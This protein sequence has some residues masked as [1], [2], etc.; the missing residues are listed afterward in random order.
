MTNSESMACYGNRH[1]AIMRPPS[2]QYWW[3]PV[4]HR[5]LK[6]A[7]VAHTTRLTARTGRIRETVA[8]I[9]PGGAQAPW[10]EHRMFPI[11]L[12][13]FK[14][15]RASCMCSTGLLLLIPL[16]HP[17][18]SGL[19]RHVSEQHPST[20]N[21]SE[22]RASCALATPGRHANGMR[23][24]REAAS[25][26]RPSGARATNERRWSGLRTARERHMSSAQAGSRSAGHKRS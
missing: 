16:L 18:R 4:D 8:A 19:F 1:R 5:E 26:R 2:R 20:S 14:L 22:L 15:R 25:E 10:L 11:S 24:T 23:A 13:P 12:D 3:K 9:Q 21:A 7:N 17:S 6:C